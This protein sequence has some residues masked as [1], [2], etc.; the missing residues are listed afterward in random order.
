MFAIFICFLGKGDFWVLLVNGFL[1]WSNKYYCL[2]VITYGVL[3]NGCCRK[4]DLLKA[5][6]VFDEMRGRGIEATVVIYMTITSGLRNQSKMDG[7]C[8]S[9]NAK[10]AFVFYYQMLSL[11]FFPMY[12]Y[13]IIWLKASIKQENHLR[14]RNFTLEMKK[15]RISLD[16]EMFMSIWRC[17]CQFFYWMFMSG[18]LP[19]QLCIWRCSVMFRVIL[20]FSNWLT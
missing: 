8:K 19:F 20:L 5:L 13:I 10:Q 6:D 3:I 1:L 16:M 18:T 7:Y 2:D 17:S 9:G 15:Y 4:G 14:L 11:V 12:L